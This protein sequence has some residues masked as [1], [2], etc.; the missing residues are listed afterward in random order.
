MTAANTFMHAAEL[1]PSLTF[2]PKIPFLSLS[3]LSRIAQQHN[4]PEEDH[5]GIQSDIIPRCE[6]AY[7]LIVIACF[8]TF[9]TLS[10]YKDKT[11]PPHTH[12][13]SH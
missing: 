1:R 5:V 7:T 2:P 4:H 6:H 13:L 3:G 9:F 11:P 12:T 10:P 8:L